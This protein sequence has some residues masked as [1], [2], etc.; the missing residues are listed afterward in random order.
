MNK[1]KEKNRFDRIDYLIFGLIII[2]FLRT[3]YVSN[4]HD[5]LHCSYVF[6]LIKYTNNSFIQ[7]LGYVFNYFITVNGRFFPLSMHQYAVYWLAFGNETLYKSYILLF[8]CI[9]LLQFRRLMFKFT[10]NLLLTRIA[11]LTAAG[12]VQYYISYHNGISGY[13]LFMQIMLMLFFF[14]EEQLLLYR[15]SQENKYFFIVLL[16]ILVAILNYEIGYLYGIYAMAMI[17]FSKKQLKFRIRDCFFVSGEMFL[18]LLVNVF[19]RLHNQVYA[20]TTPN[21]N[22]KSVFVTFMKQCWGTLPFSYAISTKLTNGLSN[23][24][25][26]YFSKVDKLDVLA[27]ILFV[28]IVYFLILSKVNCEENEGVN[29]REKMY[30]KLDVLLIFMLYFMIGL[31]PSLT[32]K[33]QTELS[34]GVAHISSYMQTFLLTLGIFLFLDGVKIEN[35]KLINSFR[36]IWFILIYGMFFVK[37]QE[38]DLDLEY[39]EN[40]IN[41]PRKMISTALEN[42]VMNGVEDGSIILVNGMQEWTIREF[43]TQYSGKIVNVIDANSVDWMKLDIASNKIYYFDYSK[44]YGDGM[45]I[46]AQISDLDIDSNDSVRVMTRQANLYLDDCQGSAVTYEYDDG[47]VFS[48]LSGYDM[49][50]LNYDIKSITMILQDINGGKE[51]YCDS[52][53]FEKGF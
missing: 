46:V 14:L 32:V 25:K 33:Y 22:I 40:Y 34:W 18:L 44:Y 30:T 17:L 21:L 39:T 2:V 36:I 15:D 35:E 16:I 28:L 53:K 20:G 43:F 42:D 50:V 8:V 9:N 24:I 6:G 5:D 51:F 19:V 37:M 1:K 48:G 10:K 49:T 52:I 11:I 45:V 29:N 4:V 26:L 13:H 3:I 31:L 47:T 12:A 27:L 23:T 41:A 7:M 38:I